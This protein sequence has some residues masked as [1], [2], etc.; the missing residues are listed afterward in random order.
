MNHLESPAGP[1]NVRVAF[2]LIELLVVI[3]IIALLIG[4][5]LPALGAARA[6]ARQIKCGSNQRQF[7][8][9]F[10]AYSVDNGGEYAYCAWE[11][12]G[13]VFDDLLADYFG[14]RLTRDQIAY[15][16]GNAATDAEKQEV[17][18]AWGGTNIVLCPSD[19]DEAGNGR[20]Y[21]MPRTLNPRDGVDGGKPFIQGGRVLG[22]MG[23]YSRNTPNEPVGVA[24]DFIPNAS[25]TLLMVE[26]PTVENDN[27]KRRGLGMPDSSSVSAARRL[28]SQANTA[29]VNDSTILHGGRNNFLHVDG[30]VEFLSPVDTVSQ[31]G[32]P[33]TPAFE[34]PEDLADPD[35]PYSDSGGRWTIDPND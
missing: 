35:G 29:F 17:L 11:A 20:T 30:H 14:V 26:R 5:L 28:G 19:E 12:G 6:T 31:N 1:R 4:I 2:T 22:A 13:I 16:A 7:G 18:D 3:S 8:V 24:A 32:I 10:T 21:K 9:S 23:T 33:R 15:G 25:G 34:S 27:N